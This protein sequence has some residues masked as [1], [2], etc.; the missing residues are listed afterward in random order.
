MKVITICAFGA[1][2]SLTAF[3]A[4]TKIRVEDLPPAVQ[5]A[6]K[7]Q[8]QRATILGASK[9]LEHGRISYE[10]ETKLNGKGRDLTFAENGSLMEVEQEVDLDSLPGRAK[11]AI[12]R[13]VAGGTI[14]KVESV[15]QGSTTSY[16]ADVTTTSGKKEE[17]AVNRDGSPHKED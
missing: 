4:E 14:K 17:V 16:E 10:V 8:T 5:A 12:Q 2:I 3:A 11:E 15:M 7:D 6:M 1:A 9:E 13:R